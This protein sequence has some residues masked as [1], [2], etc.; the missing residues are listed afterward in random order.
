MRW[1]CHCQ[2]TSCVL[3][4]SCSKSVSCIVFVLLVLLLY[5]Y[6]CLYLATQLLA[7]AH[8]KILVLSGI[9]ILA[10]ASYNGRRSPLAG[11]S[12]THRPDT[13]LLN[14]VD[15]GGKK[16]WGD[17]RPTWPPY[18]LSAPLLPVASLLHVI[19]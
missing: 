17:I 10:D 3:I 7:T 19:E 2:S 1:V 13:E 16:F 8:N 18:P 9:N 6:F 15:D 12:N 4:S 14:C 5:N 11:V